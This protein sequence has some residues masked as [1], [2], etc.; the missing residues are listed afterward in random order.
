MKK[1]T[2]IY[3]CSVSLLVLFTLLSTVPSFSF[4]SGT[5]QEHERIREEVSV[6]NVQV[7]VR[8]LYKGKP[9]LNLK[10]EDF[11]LYENKKKVEINGFFLKRK[12]LTLTKPGEP[13]GETPTVAPAPV[14]PRTFV[15]VF[16]VSNYNT[17]F[18]RA[19]D[20]LF[21]KVFVPTDRLMVFAN[22]KTHTYNN[23]ENKE[24]IKAKLIKDL[25]AEGSQAK[26]RLLGYIKRIE[27]YL[28]VHDFTRKLNRRDNG[29]AQRAL[30]F[31]KKYLLTWQEYQQK[32]LVPRT[33]RF[34]YFSR[35]L[36]KLKGEKWVL[37]FYQFEF[38]PRIRPASRTL[39][40]LRD[41]STELSN[42]N[43]ATAMAQGR[44]METLLTQ[45]NTELSLADKFPSEALTKLFYKVDA[46]FHSFFLKSTNVAFANDID[47]NQVSSD[48][49]YVLKG[50]T[51]LT[52]GRNMT[53][54]DLVKGLESIAQQEDAYYMLTYSPQS[55]KRAGKLRVK[56]KGKKYKVLYDDNFRADYINAYF[57][58][59]EQKI[60]TPDIKVT[61]L[62][63][64]KKILVFTVS[65]FLMREVE[66]KTIGQLQIRI[67]VTD[68]VNKPLYDKSQ[69]L[70]AQKK[71]L[72]LSIPTFKTIIKG[73]YNFIV[74][75][76]DMMTGKEDSS[77]QNVV[78]DR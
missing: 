33:D 44:S 65:D 45:V 4:A 77:H 5:D 75:A 24:T 9:V 51:D 52:G 53:T 32:Y 59:L 49:E 15:L 54:T 70:T 21:S 67:R 50:I 46:T 38:F 29:R 64:K 62:S 17:Y 3:G 35:Y 72:K 42:S 10:K 14:E 28:N 13:G 57:N 37:N 11:T 47:Y 69:I 12:T 39:D 76:K 30:E 73:E 18:D 58:K 27:T 66:G 20:H 7:P 63:F 56:V 6:T 31:L 19:L 22:N 1:T 26:R 34:Y 40:R 41:L 55:P 8:V 48:I 25:R 36:E 43:A 16:N 74:D 23:L 71:E 2:L 61:D 60:Q 68:K 78:I